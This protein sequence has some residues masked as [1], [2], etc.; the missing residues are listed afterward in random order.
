MF[1]FPQYWDL[2][3]YYMWGPQFKKSKKFTQGK[4][5]VTKYVRISF[6][7]WVGNPESENCS[8]RKVVESSSQ[9]QM[10]GKQ[11]ELNGLE[12]S[13]PGSYC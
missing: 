4:R 6:V 13:I 1:C 11:T 12:N 5:V 10:L 2:I 9:F 3:K 8:N 7:C